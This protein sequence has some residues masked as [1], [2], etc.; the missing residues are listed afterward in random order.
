MIPTESGY[1]ADKPLL[2]AALADFRAAEP[3][4]AELEAALENARAADT[5]AWYRDC[6]AAKAICE[7]AGVKTYAELSA[8]QRATSDAIWS[9]SHR[10]QDAA[11][12]ALDAVADPLSARFAACEDADVCLPFRWRLHPFRLSDWR[13]YLSRLALKA[14]GRR[15]RALLYA[16]PRVG[17]RDVALGDTVFFPYP[18]SAL[19]AVVKI[20]PTGRVDGRSLITESVERFTARSW[21]AEARTVPPALVREAMEWHAAWQASEPVTPK[22]S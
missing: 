9:D 21:P 22:E 4:L 11:R 17:I 6:A 15:L 18:R 20:T 14:E 10:T 2:A 19:C 5:E 16:C 3:R 13:E 7:A 12:A 8:E 1:L